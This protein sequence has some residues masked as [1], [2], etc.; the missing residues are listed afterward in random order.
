MF[1]LQFL[2]NISHILAKYTAFFVIGAAC[3]TFIWPEL[4]SWCV[5][6]QQMIVLGI[7]M[8]SMGVTL[9]SDDYRILAKR[10]LDV[11]IGACAQYT[12]MPLVAFAIAKIFNLSDG[13]T[14]GLLLVG[15]CPG[16]VSSNIMSF[17]CRGDVAFSVGMTTVSTLLAPVMTPLLMSYL[18]GGQIALEPWGMVKFLII[19]TL[20][21]VGFGSV[22]N[23]YFGKRPSFKIV[24]EIMPGI[25]VI[26]FACIV[27]GVI[28][29]HGSKFLE[30]GAIIFAC[31]ACHNGLGYLL[32]Y[33]TGSVF[34][35]N[36]AKKRT[37][38]IEVGV[39]NA[40]LATGL[41]G[42]FFPTVPEAAIASAV[43]CV[44]HSISGTILANLF[45]MWDK[46]CEKKEQKA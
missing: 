10:P 43:S 37:L 32:G 18:N 27:G 2:C 38:S 34:H 3:L 8:L 40:G 36:T 22:F 21:P 13:L 45:L 46:H 16:G 11:F 12:I 15:C 23:I 5:G 31:I 28:A 14:L 42:H 25:A 44:W 17:L 1:I 7:I 9:G 20:I 35:M 24:K 26:G 19:V 41:C 30:T 33:L 39:Q 29:V 6:T 4:F